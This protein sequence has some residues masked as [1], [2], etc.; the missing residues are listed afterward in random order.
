MT[1]HRVVRIVC[2]V[3]AMISV[4][5]VPTARAAGCCAIPPYADAKPRLRVQLVPPSMIMQNPE[6]AARRF[7]QTLFVVCVLDEANRYLYVTREMLAAW[8]LDLAAAE[9]VGVEN[10]A[11]ASKDTPFNVGVGDGKPIFVIAASGDDYDAARLLLPRYL[12]DIRKALKSEAITLA[13]PTRGSMM[14]WPAASE[15][16]RAMAAEVTTQM[17]AGPHARS[18]EL[19]HFEGGALRSLNAAEKA[20]HLR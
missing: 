2:L 9:A 14:A 7:S 12:E 8:G 6:L 3:A 18:D 19:F 10:L 5:G 16:R 1:L 17:R 4:G 15:A 11:A 13:V 20:D